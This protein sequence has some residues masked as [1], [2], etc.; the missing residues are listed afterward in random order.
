MFNWFDKL[1]NKF[2]F[3]DEYNACIMMQVDLVDKIKYQNNMIYQLSKDDSGKAQKIL[4]LQ[5][6]VKELNSSID[7]LTALNTAYE[8][9]IESL[10]TALA[11]YGEIEVPTPQY[12]DESKKCY[13]PYRQ[14][15]EKASNGSYSINGFI[16]NDPREMYITSNFQKK[17]VVEKGW[18]KLSKYEKLMAVWKWTSNRNT[19]VYIYDNGDNWQFAI[20]TIYRKGGDCEDSTILFITTCRLL[21]IQANE[22]FNAVGPTSFGYHSYPIVYLTSNDIKGTNLSEAGWYI[23]ESTL[24]GTP[25]KPKPLKHSGYY[26]DNGGIQN[27]QFAGRVKPQ[28]AEEFNLSSSSKMPGQRVDNSDEKKIKIQQYWYDQGLLKKR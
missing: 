22:I 26:I 9:D 3:R 10:K 20:E 23:F 11:I 21:G 16:I 15:V 19:R 8:Q 13:M 5:D 28:F 1:I 25:I 18:K 6:I 17:L 2:T 12:L 27:W 7:F 4:E 24:N 14:V